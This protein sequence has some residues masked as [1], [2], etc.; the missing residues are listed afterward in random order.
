[1][2]KKFLLL[3]LAL[4]ILTGCKHP[5]SVSNTPPS[6]TMAVDENNGEF[7]NISGLSVMPINEET[8]YVIQTVTFKDP[9]PFNY[10]AADFTEQV[11]D[12]ALGG[13][14]NVSFKISSSDLSQLGLIFSN[15]LANQKIPSYLTE[16][17]AWFQYSFIVMSPDE[18]YVF[19]GGGHEGIPGY[20][21]FSGGRWINLNTLLQEKLQDQFQEDYAFPQLAIHV[22]PSYLR[23][24]EQNYCCDTLYDVHNDERVK[25]RKVFILDRETYEIL[26]EDKV[27]RR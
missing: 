15:E 5:P 27:L 1:M 7:L 26:Q 23:V 19:D 3:C 18:F 2:L 9:L 13:D 11:Q 25:Y 12:M 4:N 8:P 21:Y 24:E 10:A 17:P 16:N 14:L 6:E 22:S 20:K